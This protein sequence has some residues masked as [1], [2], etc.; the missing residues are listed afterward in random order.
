VGFD[1]PLYSPAFAIGFNVLF[2]DSAGFSLGFF[3]CLILFC[4]GCLSWK[5]YAGFRV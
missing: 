3:G 5:N 2:L 1:L 4:L